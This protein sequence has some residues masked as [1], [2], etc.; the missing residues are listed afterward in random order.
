[1]DALAA[2]YN[3]YLD[4]HPSIKP[5]LIGHFEPWQAFALMLCSICY[6]FL[7]QRVG[8]ENSGIGDAAREQGIEHVGHRTLKA[9]CR[10]RHAV[11]QPHQPFFGSGQHYE[12]H[13]H[14]DEGWNM[15]GASFFGRAFPSTGRNENLGWSHTVNEPA[16]LDV[17]QETFNN[18]KDPLAYAMAASTAGPWSGLNR[19]ASR[20]VSW[21]GG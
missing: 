15:S 21:P 4:T 1:M 19:S 12:G 14:S 18:P 13:V 20:P 6:V 3:F 17:Y 11:S 16:V 8:I 5:R 7:F 9:C 2:A 10:P